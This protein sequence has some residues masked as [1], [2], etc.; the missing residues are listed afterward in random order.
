MQRN[1]EAAPIPKLCPVPRKVQDHP[2]AALHNILISMINHFP[3]TII[4]EIAIV[5][6]ASEKAGER[7]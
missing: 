5:S 2:L 6:V 4:R 1:N 3:P 7:K